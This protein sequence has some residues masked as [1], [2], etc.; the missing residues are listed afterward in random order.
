MLDITKVVVAFTAAPGHLLKRCTELFMEGPLRSFG[1]PFRRSRKSGG[2]RQVIATIEDIE[3]LIIEGRI[4]VGDLMDPILLSAF[5]AH[6]AEK[7]PNQRSNNLLAEIREGKYAREM[8][9]V[10]DE[11]APL[12]AY[13]R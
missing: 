8:R 1:A 13:E 5:R 9:E 10:L 3:R 4:E 2:G 12:P 11:V 6:L 7:Y